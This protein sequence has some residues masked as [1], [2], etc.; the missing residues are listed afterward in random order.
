MSTYFHRNMGK[1]THLRG[2]PGA[3]RR[4]QGGCEEADRRAP[5]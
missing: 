2:D 4:V 1:M 5:V 3:G